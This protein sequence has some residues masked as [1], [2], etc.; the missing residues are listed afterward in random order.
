M[1]SIICLTM[2]ALGAALLSSCGECPCNA[3]H[4]D[5]LRDVVPTTSRSF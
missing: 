1:K 4:S 2:A 5:Y 3:S